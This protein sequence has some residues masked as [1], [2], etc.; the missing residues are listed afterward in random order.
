M[1]MRRYIKAPFGISARMN[2][3]KHDRL[4]LILQCKLFSHSIL[5][6][7]QAVSKI[8]YDLSRARYEPFALVRLRRPACPAHTIPYQ[9]AHPHQP[10]S[11][12]PRGCGQPPSGVV[13]CRPL[14]S[15]RPAG[16]AHS[17]GRSL[18]PSSPTPTPD[19]AACAPPHSVRL[20]LV[21]QPRAS[22][23]RMV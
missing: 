7:P 23:H 19:A 14:T 3:A 2:K 15:R 5:S 6:R 13:S 16:V 9:R 10:T 11:A 1:P 12:V 20:S 8:R 4:C 17:S 18:A 21:C 22:A